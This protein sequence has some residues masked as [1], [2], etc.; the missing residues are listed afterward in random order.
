MTD[1]AVSRPSTS[2]RSD[3]AVCGVAIDDGPAPRSDAPELGH[4]VLAGAGAAVPIVAH[5]KYRVRN[6]HLLLDGTD[7]G[8]DVAPVP[9]PRFYDLTTGAGTPYQRVARL[10]GP[11]VLA[12]T[13]G[14]EPAVDPAELVQ[15]A[16]DAVRLDGVTSLVMT[17]GAAGE[18]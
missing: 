17:T 10:H 13:V 5:S 2:L 11:D 6:G 12:I 7:L 8:L 15:V 9:R 16:A 14:D 3:L 4:L 18:A 1:A